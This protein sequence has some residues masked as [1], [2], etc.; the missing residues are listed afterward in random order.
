[1]IIQHDNYVPR[2]LKAAPAKSTILAQV[3][4]AR[5]A[6]HWTSRAESRA[7]TEQSTNYICTNIVIGLI[8]RVPEQN[9]SY[10]ELSSPPIEH[11][12]K[13]MQAATET[14]QYTR[15]V[16]NLALMRSKVIIIL[17]I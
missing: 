3:G 14:I 10:C 11:S 9:L 4:L 16:Q 17:V 7:K 15:K 2:Q 5:T 1:V 6:Y 8:A 13:T 12:A